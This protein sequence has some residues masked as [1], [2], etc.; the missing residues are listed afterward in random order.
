MEIPL[1]QNGRT[2]LLASSVLLSLVG[3][4]TLIPIAFNNSNTGQIVG[5]DL[6]MAGGSY[7]LVSTLTS[8]VEVTEDEATLAATGG[9]LGI[10]H[11]WL[12]TYLIGGEN[13]NYHT[14]AGVSTLTSIGEYI[15]G[16]YLARDLKMKGGTASV[17]GF[18]GLFG[19]LGGFAVSVAV[20]PPSSNVPSVPLLTGLVLAGSLGGYYSGYMLSLDHQYSDGDATV[21][22]L[23]A[24]LG[25]AVPLANLLEAGVNNHVTLPLASLAGCLVATFAVHS[26]TRHTNLYQSQAINF[27]VATLAGGL[28]CTGISLLAKGSVQTSVALASIGAVG[29]LCLAFATTPQNKSEG[30]STG[31]LN[32][33]MNPTALL[34]THVTRP[35]PLAGLTYTF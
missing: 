16:Y 13:A 35:I 12:L 28:A 4:G 25:T 17:I 18:G 3:Y 1:D 23:G 33:Q 6:L 24:A 29:G 30:Q 15:G 34:S 21:L 11:G 31:S 32:F 26:A 27:A 9:V 19:G 14:G 10:G 5:A 22:W 7:L 20:L 8:H 2:S